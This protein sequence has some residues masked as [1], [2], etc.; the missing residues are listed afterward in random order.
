MQLTI[1]PSP[2]ITSKSSTTKTMLYV[3]I[4]LVPAIVMATI[5]FGVRALMLV[6]ISALTCVA[7]EYFSR[8]VMKRNNTISDLSAVVTGVILAL[9][10]PSTLPFWM[11]IV[12]DIFAIIIA[13]QLFGGLGQNFANPAIV[14]R[15]ALILSFGSQM[16]HWITPFDYVGGVDAVTMATPLADLS[17]TDITYSYLDLFLGTV[18]GSLGETSAMA[19]LIGGIFLIATR[20]ISPVLPV[21]FIGTVALMSYL[22]GEDPLY[23]ILSGGLMLGALFMATDYVTSP[24]TARGKIIFGIGCG[25]ITCVIRFYASLPE[26]VSY[27]ILLM[28]ILT[29]YIDMATKRK[30]FGYKKA[31]KVVKEAK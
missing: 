3:I 19:L 8:L 5:V 28:N 27:A 26:G 20:I 23:Q 16:T 22:V 30:R 2:H 14:A 18:P 1:S 9:N 12:G 15:I 17:G 24:I 7:L 6:I 31:P 11:M 21:S 29:P 25:I 4:A 13:K 10:V